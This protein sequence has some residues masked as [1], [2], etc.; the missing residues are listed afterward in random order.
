MAS[1]P[2]GSEEAAR[3]T[4]CSTDGSVLPR[5]RDGGVQRPLWF[6]CMALFWRLGAADSE[7]S[8]LDEAQVLAIQMR[9]LAAE[10]LGVVTMQY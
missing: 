2:A 8:I 7:F 5:R 6:V 4:P 10:E 9:K 1:R 3:S